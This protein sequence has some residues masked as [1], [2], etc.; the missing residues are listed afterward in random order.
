M[1]ILETAE[2]IAS[3]N[4]GTVEAFILAINAILETNK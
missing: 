4:G 2:V 3:Q 1:S